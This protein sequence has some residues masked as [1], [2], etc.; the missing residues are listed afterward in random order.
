MASGPRLEYTD[1]LED[2]KKRAVKTT[3]QT[4]INIEDNQSIFSA[5]KGSKSNASV[6]NLRL[7]DANLEL[8]MNQAPSNLARM[9]HTVMKSLKP[10][11]TKRQLTMNVVESPIRVEKTSLMQ[12][13]ILRS[14]RQYANLQGINENIIPLIKP[15]RAYEL[16]KVQSAMTLKDKP[17][18]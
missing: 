2:Q 10:I 18:D 1:S 16:T 13:N 14:K 17:K 11:D 3:V 12:A 5:A 15:K 6:P 8:L 9:K 4:S 7:R